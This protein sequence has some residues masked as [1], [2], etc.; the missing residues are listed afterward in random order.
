M[1]NLAAGDRVYSTVNGGIMSQPPL[2][3]VVDLIDGTGDDLVR[4]CWENGATQYFDTIVDTACAL[5]VFTADSSEASWIGR[6][7]GFS[8]GTLGRL[9]GVIMR[10]FVVA[11]VRTFLVQADQVANRGDEI[12]MYSLQP[13]SSLI[14]L[15]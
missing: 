10:S 5:Q 3:G 7:L 14:V 2:F 9:N 8:V 6:R 13:E 11:S 1:A 15:S 12:L 4:V